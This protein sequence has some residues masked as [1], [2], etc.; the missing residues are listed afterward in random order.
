MGFSVSRHIPGG[1]GIGRTGG[2]L[3]SVNGPVPTARSAGIV[4]DLMQRI[5]RG[6]PGAKRGPD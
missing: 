3:E 6:P 4:L 1:V 2:P 5:I